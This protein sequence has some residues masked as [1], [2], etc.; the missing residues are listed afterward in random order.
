[1]NA[2]IAKECQCTV[3]PFRGIKVDYRYG[4]DVELLEVEYVLS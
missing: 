1:M 3:V 4:V 2:F